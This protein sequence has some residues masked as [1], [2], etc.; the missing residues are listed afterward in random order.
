MFV[1]CFFFFKQKTAYEMRISDW[2]SDVCSSD[3]PLQLEGLEPAQAIADDDPAPRSV[4]D[5]GAR[6]MECAAEPDQ[7]VARLA[8]CRDGH[9]FAGVTI[10]AQ[11]MTAR[12]EPSCAILRCEEIGR[13]SCRERVCQYV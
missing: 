9:A 2:S 12:P 7:R 1:G 5:V 4:A 11:P 8:H 6:A 13:A 3:L 10:V